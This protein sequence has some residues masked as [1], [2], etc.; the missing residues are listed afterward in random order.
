MKIQNMFTLGACAWLAVSAIV[1]CSDDQSNKPAT[2]A[3]AVGIAASNPLGQ[4]VQAA[5]DHPEVQAAPVPA[6]V[7]CAAPAKAV[8]GVCIHP[9]LKRV[10]GRDDDCHTQPK[11][12]E[13]V[14]SWDVTNNTTHLLFK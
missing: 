14:K 3:E 9:S 12:I 4:A 10:N 8:D 11:C 5:I 7:D 13:L 2:I 6:V 1:G